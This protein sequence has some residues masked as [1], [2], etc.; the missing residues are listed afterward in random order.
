MRV[1]HKRTGDVLDFDALLKPLISD[2]YEVVDEPKPDR[3]QDVT[4][5]CGVDGLLLIHNGEPLHAWGDQCYRLRKVRVW[6][7][8]GPD[9]GDG[10]YPRP[11]SEQWAFIV[12]RKGE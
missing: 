8:V 3:W 6:N 10:T 2:N 9:V 4:G 12:E 1:R 7:R 11:Y 5:E